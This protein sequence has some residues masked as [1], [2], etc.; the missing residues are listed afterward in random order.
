MCNS[1]GR[2]FGGALL[3]VIFGTFIP[4]AADAT[5]HPSTISTNGKLPVDFSMTNIGIL[6]FLLSAPTLLV[7]GLAQ[8]AA[9]LEGWEGNTIKTAPPGVRTFQFSR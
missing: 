6:M 7:E 8:V 9:R 2:F 5:G 1:V 3:A 4:V